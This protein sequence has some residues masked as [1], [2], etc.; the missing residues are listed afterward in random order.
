MS[1]GHQGLFIF[2]SND[3]KQHLYDLWCHFSKRYAITVFAWCILDN[4]FHMILQVEDDSLARFMKE[5]NGTYGTWYRK[6]HGGRGSVYDGRFKSTVIE[7]DNYLL[8]AIRYLFLNPVRA[9]LVS[10]PFNYHW[11]SCRTVLNSTQT[12]TNNSILTTHF[13]DIKQFADWLNQD[14]PS[15]LETSTDPW[16]RTLGSQKFRFTSLKLSNRRK[17]ETT[18]DKTP[19]K[20][21]N[22]KINAINAGEII[23]IFVTE[24]KITEKT[25]TERNWTASRLRGKLILLLRDE[26]GLKFSEIHCLKPFRNFSRSTLTSLY[27]HTKKRENE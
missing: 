24:N 22:R 6:K 20:R 4:H 15:E 27:H 10:N 21:L 14:N 23:T 8:Q 7:D 5:T 3:E 2:Q 25:L 13:T 16:G 9:R 11:S 19:G 17:C 18:D 12:I 1:R 26:H